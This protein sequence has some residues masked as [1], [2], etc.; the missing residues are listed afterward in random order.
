[1]PQWVNDLDR[2]RRNSIYLSVSPT[3]IAYVGIQ[4]TCLSPPPY[5]YLP[6]TY[7]DRLRRNSIYLSVSPSAIVC[8][9][10]CRN[11]IYLPVSM[12]NPPRKHDSRQ[13]ITGW[14]AGL[15]PLA[16]DRSLRRAVAEGGG[17]QLAKGG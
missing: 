13:T 15:Y 6:V 9:G 12:E 16:K 14:G 4:Y 5:T 8:I 17:W 1:M 11:T 2:L 10:I 3:W 7:V